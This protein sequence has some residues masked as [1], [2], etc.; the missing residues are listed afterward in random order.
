MAAGI[1][2]RTGTPRCDAEGD[3]SADSRPCTVIVSDRHETLQGDLPHPHHPLLRFGQGDYRVDVGPD[4]IEADLGWPCRWL[5]PLLRWMG[6]A[7]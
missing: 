4:E 3:A 1:V 5:M 7:R 6:V 2:E